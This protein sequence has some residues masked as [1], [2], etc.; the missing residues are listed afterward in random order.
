MFDKNFDSLSDIFNSSN[1][2]DRCDTEASTQPRMNGILSPHEH[3]ERLTT[4]L[5]TARE[6]YSEYSRLALQGGHKGLPYYFILIHNSTKLLL[7]ISKFLSE[8][9]K[10]EKPGNA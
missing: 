7:N 9:A 2:K 10:F 4:P 3:D 6:E 5:R 8:F 1:S